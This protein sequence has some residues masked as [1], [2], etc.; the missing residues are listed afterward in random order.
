MVAIRLDFR[1]QG[2]G[3]ASNCKADGGSDLIW[4]PFKKSMHLRSEHGRF[5]MF[6]CLPI[7]LSTY[8]RTMLLLLL[9]LLLP[10]HHYYY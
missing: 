10:H 7:Y 8:M 3:I 2:L 1:V 5:C 4:G 9:L 6:A